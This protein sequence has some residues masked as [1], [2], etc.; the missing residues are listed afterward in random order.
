[1]LPRGRPKKDGSA[2]GVP[3]SLARA[4]EQGIGDL[5]LAPD[6]FYS[7]TPGELAL[8]I[9]GANRKQQ[10]RVDEILSY[11]RLAAWL[12]GRFCRIA[13]RDGE[14]PEFSD[15]NKERPTEE[16]IQAEAEQAGIRGP[17]D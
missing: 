3:W 6:V 14:Y 11:I 16:T 10:S 1:V 7:L 9:E 5:R 4:R 12:I 2:P 13:F 15:L 8:M 17:E